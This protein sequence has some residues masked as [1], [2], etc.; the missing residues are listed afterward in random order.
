MSRSSV[1]RYA[2]TPTAA[3]SEHSRLRHFIDALG[4]GDLDGVARL[5]LEN[6]QRFWAAMADDI[7]IAWTRRFGRR[8]RIH[9]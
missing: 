4:A 9:P 1:S 6:P 2:W 7:G 8:R 3:Q 5:A